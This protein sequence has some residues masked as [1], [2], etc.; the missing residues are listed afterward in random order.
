MSDKYL[1]I[2][3][4]EVYGYAEQTH[5]YSMLLV[6]HAIITKED[7]KW[8]QGYCS[9]ELFTIRGISDTMPFEFPKPRFYI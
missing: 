1:Y 3:Y 7:T 5:I 2:I 4:H 6:H 8:T 9:H